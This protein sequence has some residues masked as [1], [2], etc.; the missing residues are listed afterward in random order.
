MNFLLED[1]KHIYWNPYFGGFMMGLIILFSFYITGRG[2]GASGAIKSTVVATVH[3][4][5]SDH[6]ENSAYYSQFLKGE[7]SPLNSWLVFQVLGLIAGAFFSGAVNNRLKLRI[8]HAPQITTKTRLIFVLLGGLLFGMGSQLARGCTSG[9]ALSGFAS[10][11]TG[12][13][14]I[15]ISIFASAY[16]FAYFFRKLWI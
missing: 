7:K 16:L 3:T 14:I 10:Y 13:F 5:A 4:I 15:M 1:K 8:Q 12:G 6:A 2:V 11:S 9:G